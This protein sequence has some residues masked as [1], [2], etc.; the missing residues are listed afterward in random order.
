MIDAFVTAFK[1]GIEVGFLLWGLR[2]AFR[3][4]F[5]IIKKV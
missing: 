4:F 5:A 3:L 2:Q 1:V